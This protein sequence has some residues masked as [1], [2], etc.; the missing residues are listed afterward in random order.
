[1]KLFFK[2]RNAQRAFNGAGKK[3]DCGTKAQA[4]KRWAVEYSQ[5]KG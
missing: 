3:V 4:G 5:Q 1:M 2:S